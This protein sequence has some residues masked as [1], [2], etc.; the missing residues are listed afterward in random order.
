MNGFVAC[1]ISNFCVV[2]NNCW[3]LKEMNIYYTLKAFLLKLDNILLLKY[4]YI[5]DILNHK[6]LHRVCNFLS[7]TLNFGW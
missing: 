5:I 7:Y 1:D 3:T 4:T 6:L 2:L